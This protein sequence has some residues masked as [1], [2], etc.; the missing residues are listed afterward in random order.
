ML[1]QCVVRLP[2]VNGICVGMRKSGALMFPDW[3]AGKRVPQDHYRVQ[4]ASP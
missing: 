4:R 1:V 3:E 2:D